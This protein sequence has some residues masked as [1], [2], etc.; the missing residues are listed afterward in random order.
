MGCT[1]IKTGITTAFLMVLAI[2][3]FL[4]GFFLPSYIE[5]QIDLNIVVDSTSSPLFDNWQNTT[6]PMFMKFY[7]FNITNP[8]EVE[9]GG[10]PNLTEL[11]PYSY[12]EIKYK[13]NITFDKNGREVS[14]KTYQY[15]I[16]DEAT[17]I[18]N[19]FTDIITT[20]N[21]PLIGI[22]STFENW[23]EKLAMGAIASITNASLFTQQPVNSLIFGYKDPTLEYLHELSP[24]VNPV[25]QLQVNHTSM[26]NA[27]S[28][29]LLDTFI[30][31]KNN[32]DKMNS[33]LKWQNKSYIECWATESAG[34]INGSDGTQF[35]P[36]VKKDDILYVF[37]DQVFRFGATYCNGEVNSF[38][39][40]LYRF[41]INNDQSKNYS[42][43]PANADYYQNGPSGVNN[44]TRCS[45]GVPLFI[46]KPHFL[47]ADPIYS[48]SVLGLSA[49]R[50]KHDTYLD[51]E[52]RTGAVLGAAKRLQLNAYLFDLF[53]LY[54]NV[55]N[56]Y[57]PVFW[58]EES[59]T[60]TSDLAE[61]F[62]DAIYTAENYATVG[63]Y[64]GYILGSIFSLVSF[65][66]LADTIVRIRKAKHAYT[67]LS[68]NS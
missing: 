58:A 55:T 3:L 62:K 36:R 19:P 21:L 17:T 35:H 65:F 66:F 1:P 16:F 52:P 31:G 29:S 12:R 7:I 44:I 4:E 57:M 30:T 39:I 56:V 22:F 9:L 14:F 51:I 41:V 23:W 68:T 6:A 5:Q 37:V 26:E 67:I 48:E 13:F 40:K 24:D 60:L 25:F 64:T 43:N 28:L 50:E 34:I 54:P 27:D 11:G 2:G 42:E 10:K 59:G 45:G 61:Q 8:K 53:L 47:D 18:G 33:Y 38:G 63:M 15:Y 20:V 32:L 46:S 49:N